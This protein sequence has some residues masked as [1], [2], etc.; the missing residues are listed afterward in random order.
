[1]KSYVMTWEEA[2]KVEPDLSKF[3]YRDICQ[4][5]FVEIVDCLNKKLRAERPQRVV[6]GFGIAPVFSRV[7]SME[8]K[9]PFF[10]ILES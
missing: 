2:L 8:S 3:V 1:M 9:Y 5:L 10:V 7:S 6:S 4:D